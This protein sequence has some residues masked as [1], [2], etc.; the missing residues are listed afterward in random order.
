MLCSNRFAYSSFTL[1]STPPSFESESL[2]SKSPFLAALV[3]SAT[4][5]ETLGASVSLASG[6]DFLGAL[7]FSSLG[8]SALGFSALG[9]SALGFS[10][11][12]FSALGFSALGCSAL[13][14]EAFGNLAILSGCIF[15]LLTIAKTVEGSSRV[16]AV[17]IFTFFPR[18]FLLYLFSAVGQRPCGERLNY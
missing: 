2:S 15:G 11:L 5:C 14:R 12:G 6:C 9:F 10:A 4:G 8:F 18:L 7:G 17:G 16:L 1:S 13:G 3:S